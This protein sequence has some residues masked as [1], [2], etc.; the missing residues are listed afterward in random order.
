MVKKH[1]VI[2]LLT[3]EA[4]VTHKGRSKPMLWDMLKKTKRFKFADT[5]KV[6]PI[7]LY[8]NDPS[9]DDMWYFEGKTEKIATQRVVDIVKATQSLKTT[10]KPKTSKQASN[11]HTH[12]HK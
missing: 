4:N 1:V 12:T 11:K 10:P 9:Q 2:K 7:L 3:V 8:H 5:E 6:K